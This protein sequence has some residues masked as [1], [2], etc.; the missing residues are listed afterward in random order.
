MA[1][2]KAARGQ[3]W[4]RIDGAGRLHYIGPDGRSL[5]GKWLYLGDEFETGDSLYWKRCAECQ[6]RHDRSRREKAQP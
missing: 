4:A 1:D 5:C 6:R 2:K 3:G